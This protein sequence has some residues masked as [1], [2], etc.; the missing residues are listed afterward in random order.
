MSILSG[1]QIRTLPQ[2]NKENSY[3][4]WR[5]HYGPWH[6]SKCFTD[7]LADL[8]KSAGDETCVLCDNVLNTEQINFFS[9]VVKVDFPEFPCIENLAQLISKWPN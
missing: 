4:M 8:N 9:R 7:H 5:V 2:Y 3:Y 6:Y 1:G